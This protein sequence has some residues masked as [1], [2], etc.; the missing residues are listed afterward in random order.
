MNWVTEVRFWALNRDTFT[1]PYIPDIDQGQIQDLKLGVAQMDW[2]QGPW[3][4]YVIHIDVYA[5]L[6]DN[7]LIDC[8]L[9]HRG[10]TFHKYVFLLQYYI[11]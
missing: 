7:W 10:H 3:E 9:F 1:V 6:A 2:K 5:Q 11:S 4:C 8:R